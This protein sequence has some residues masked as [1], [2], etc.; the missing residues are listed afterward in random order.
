MWQ[1]WIN[2]LAGIWLIISPY[3]GF[4]TSAL[5]TNLVVT[6][7]IVAILGLWGGLSTNRSM[8]SMPR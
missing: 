4:T 1:N 5:T 3:L 7:I 8:S 6:G 2:F